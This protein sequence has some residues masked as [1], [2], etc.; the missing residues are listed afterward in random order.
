MRFVRLLCVALLCGGASGVLA[1]G[2]ETHAA[3]AIPEQNA[4]VTPL[5]WDIGGPFALVDHTGG[6]RTQVEPDGKMQLLFFGYAN[7]PGICSTALPMMAEVTDLLAARDIAVSPV[8]ITIDPELDT[9]ASMGPA[10]AGISD[11]FVGLTGTPEA[12]AVAYRAFQIR[13][14]RIM[15]DPRHGPIYAHGSHIYLLDGAGKVLTLLPPVL[16]PDQAAGIVARYA[17]L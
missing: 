6:T 1:H 10:L 4:A 12:L 9:V 11:D 8:L 2:T 5:P 17:D 13:F 3:P 14:T 7:C 16:S 15:D